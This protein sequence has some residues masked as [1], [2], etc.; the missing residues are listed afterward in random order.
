MFLV[1]VHEFDGKLPKIQNA[2]PYVEI[3][4]PFLNFSCFEELFQK[5]VFSLKYLWGLVWTVGL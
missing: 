1:S 4:F 5:G 2:S 3:R